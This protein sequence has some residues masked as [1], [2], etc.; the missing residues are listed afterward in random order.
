[1]P[2]AAALK[3][4]SENKGK[5]LKKNVNKRKQENSTTSNYK[6]EVSSNSRLVNLIKNRS[7]R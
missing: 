4:Y 3:I 7:L 2:K 6:F 5:P 1:M